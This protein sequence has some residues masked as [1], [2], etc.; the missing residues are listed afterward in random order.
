MTEHKF[1]ASG[2][3]HHVVSFSGGRTSALMVYLMEQKRKAGEISNVHYIYMDTGA[4]HPLTY[5]FVREVVKFWGI[6]LTVL[7]V[8]INPVLGQGNGYK[9]W[10]PADI[11]TRMD[12][13]APFAAMMTKYGTPY[14]GGAFCTDRMKLQPFTK[15]CND[16]FGKGNYTTWLGIRADEPKRLAEK[17]GIRYLAELSDFEKQDVIDWWQGQPFDLLVP[18]HL[19]NC[20]FCIKKS[21]AKLAMAIKDEPGLFRVFN[22]ELHSKAV[23]ITDRKTPSDIMYRGHLS[24]EGIAAMYAAKG[25]DELAASMKG[26]KRFDSG[27][28]SESCEVFSCQLDML[29]DLS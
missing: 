17:E 20:V 13:M 27:S 23:R 5:R 19:G 18:E 26:A 10:S 14:I 22:H 1:D 6:P 16:S 29:E 3:R 8:D 9:V 25:R 7:S 28:C 2:T 15:Y 11:Q 21:T 12:A 24:L 4:E